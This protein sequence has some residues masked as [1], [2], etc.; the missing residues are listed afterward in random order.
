[1]PKSEVIFVTGGTGFIGRNTIEQLGQHRRLLAPTHVELDLVDEGAVER[2]FNNNKVDIVIHAAAIVDGKKDVSVSDQVKQNLRMFFNLVRQEKKW[3]KMIFFG[4]GAEY[5]KRRDIADITEEQFDERVPADEYGFA[6]YICA[7]YIERHDKIINL[8]CFGV[9]GKYEDYTRRFI[10]DAIC[11][12]LAGK[13]ITI[14]QNVFF[15]YLY[16][17]DLVRII[18]Y[19]IGHKPRYKFYNIGSGK[20]IDLLE[21]SRIVKKVTGSDSEIVVKNPGLNKEYTC[22]TSRLRGELGKFSFTPHEQAITEMVEWYK[23]HW[24]EL[25]KN[26]PSPVRPGATG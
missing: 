22:D 24:Q 26:L 15:D 2:F 9:Y 8:C 16:I 17:N 7:K 5:D 1:M 21:L 10:S 25:S 13:P 4:S 12:V 23:N 6:K 19:F 18:D 14:R 11:R 20:K 3:K